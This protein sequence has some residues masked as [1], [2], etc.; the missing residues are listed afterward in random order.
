MHR[1]K[2]ANVELF[3]LAEPLGGFGQ[4]GPLQGGLAALWP[5]IE[6]SVERGDDGSMVSGWARIATGSKY[7]DLIDVD[8]DSG[9]I[10]R[11]F[12]ATRF[13]LYPYTI[14]HFQQPVYPKY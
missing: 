5:W 7:F 3:G 8:I 14:Y 13:S 1:V 12:L 2:C 6:R 10:S 11:S 4:A 9:D